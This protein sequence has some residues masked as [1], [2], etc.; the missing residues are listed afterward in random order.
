MMTAPFFAPFLCHTSASVVWKESGLL[1]GS[2]SGDSNV[3]FSV[4]AWKWDMQ[5]KVF[6]VH[7]FGIMW[8]AKSLWD[9]KAYR[10]KNRDYLLR[11]T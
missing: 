11:R 7:T 4:T 2:R 3:P 1:K 9:V 6:I 8:G 5:L 10:I